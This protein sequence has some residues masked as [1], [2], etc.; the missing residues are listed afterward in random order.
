M[1]KVDPDSLRALKAIAR[2]QY[3]QSVGERTVGGVRYGSAM[4]RTWTNEENVENADSIRVQIG[5]RTDLHGGY[6]SHALVRQLPY[7]RITARCLSNGV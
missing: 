3:D 5:R 1:E 4:H 2:I 6:A 7:H